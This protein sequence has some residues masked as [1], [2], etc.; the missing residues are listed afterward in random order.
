[1]AFK[2][3]ELDGQRPVTIYK[4]RGSRSL[5]LSIRSDGSLRVTIPTWTPY[6]AGLTFA[7]SRLEWITRHAPPK[8]ALL[9]HNQAIGKAHRLQFVPAASATK[10]ASRVRQTEVI[11]THPATQLSSDA[12]VQAAATRASIR[13]LR[14]QAEKLLPI[15]LEELAQKHGFRYRN[16]VIKHLK[17]R[18]GSCDQHKNIALNLYLMQLPWQ[19]IDYVLLHELTHTRVMRHGPAFWQTMEQIEPNVQALRK[20]IRSHRPVLIAAGS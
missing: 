11:I 10:I 6:A 17:T 15:R 3:F 14:R 19:L 18:W 12:M 8:A 5:R 16:V 2:Q 13:A 7:Y 4:R 9:E 20:A 1:M